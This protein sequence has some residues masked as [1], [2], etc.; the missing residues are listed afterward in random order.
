M[1]T[2][3]FIKD[4]IE[5][6]IGSKTAFKSISPMDEQQSHDI[7]VDNMQSD[8][9]ITD[10]NDARYIKNRPEN[11]EVLIKGT[12]S[13]GNINGTPTGSIPV[14]GGLSTATKT[15]IGDSGT[16]DVTFPSVGTSSYLP[17]LFIS[18]TDD[19]SNRGITTLKFR[20][21]TPT[22]FQIGIGEVVNESQTITIFVKVTRF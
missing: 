12:I 10:I 4:Y 15:N 7:I 2:L 1:A 18:T 19:N 3:Q 20:N 22:G 11:D 9:D 21:R 14:T 8:F 13:F 17:E 5:A 16:V 6:R